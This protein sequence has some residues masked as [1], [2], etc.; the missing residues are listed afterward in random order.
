[1]PPLQSATADAAGM[2]APP[3]CLPLSCQAPA[4]MPQYSGPSM[5]PPTLEQC[6]EMWELCDMPPHIQAHSRLVACV[7]EAIAR[8]ARDVRLYDCVQS[9]TAAAL[10]HDIAKHYTIL[11]GGNHAYLG[12][13]WAMELTGNPA[14]AQGVVHHVF[15]PW[16]L[17]VDAYFLPLTVIYADKRAMHD[18]L[19]TVEE[20]FEDLFERY[21]TNDFIRS[22]IELSKRQSLDLEHE[23][24][25]RLGMDL[26]ACTFDCG[27][28]VE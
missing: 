11:Y 9:V 20:R 28:L 12:G 4:A 27:W 23:L 25:K 22:R 1:M 8:R 3:S 17:D 10:L 24:N 7:A 13:V 5:Q 6:M 15:W 21:A 26:D 14:V 18:R 16:R 19:V 2:K